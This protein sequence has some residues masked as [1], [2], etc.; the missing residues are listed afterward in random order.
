VNVRSLAYRTD[1]I[2]PRFDGVVLDKGDYLVVK[3]PENPSF[4][5]GNFLLFPHA[6]TQG[7][8]ERWRDLF[9][10]EFGMGPRH[11]AFG[12]DETGDRPAGLEPF[13]QAGFSLDESV[14]LATDAAREPPKL[15]G[16][17]TVRPLRSPSEWDAALENQLRYRPPSFEE[18]SYCTFKTKQMQ[19]YR[20]M[21]EAGL[22][23]W[24]GAFVDGVLAADLGVFVE[25]GL[26]RYQ[27]VGTRPEYR[28]RGLAG[29]LVYRAAE[30]MRAHFGAHTL[31]IVADKGSVAADIYRSV[32]FDDVEKQ[33]G[34][35]WWD[36]S[37]H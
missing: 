1:L 14:V 11:M 16:E 4:M 23:H 7:D 22:G 20:R 25:N 8:L 24:F 30:Y 9:R 10:Q 17:A 13:A 33:Y 6:P 27:S 32:G 37:K 2:F 29:T 21:A 12:I 35:I 15:N 26:A 19:R 34:L 36:K 3:T 28:R 5:W 31:V 18:A